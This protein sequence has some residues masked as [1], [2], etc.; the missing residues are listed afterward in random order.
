MLLSPGLALITVFSQVLAIFGDLSNS[1]TSNTRIAE[2][3]TFDYVVVGGG[4]AGLTIAAR[5]AEQK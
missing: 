3:A 5:L 4:T 2:N 1:Y